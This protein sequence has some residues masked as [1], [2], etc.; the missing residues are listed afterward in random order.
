MQPS[1]AMAKKYLD[2]ETRQ[3]LQ[4]EENKAHPY[5]IKR[6]VFKDVDG[7]KKLADLELPGLLQLPTGSCDAVF[8]RGARNS[9]FGY[10]PINEYIRDRQTILDKNN[11]T[12]TFLNSHDPDMKAQVYKTTE[13]VPVIEK[14]NIF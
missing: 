6:I 4:D 10:I 7:S 9:G 5:S 8:L 13:S 2:D 3:Y 1:R 14:N 11:T 12:G